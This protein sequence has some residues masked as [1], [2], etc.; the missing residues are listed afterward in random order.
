[1]AAC[2]AAAAVLTGCGGDSGASAGASSPA[3]APSRVCTADD[4]KT[5]GEFGKAPEITVPDDCTPP[6]KLVIKDLSAGT[7][8]E[9]KPGQQVTMNYTLVTW[10]DKKQLDSS[11]GKEP[12]SLSL[13]AGEVIKGW[14]EGLTG[15]KQGGRRLLI[16][17]PDLGY[18]KGGNGIAPNETLVFV[19]DAVAVPA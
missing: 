1:M 2:V 14:D 7:G 18:G 12:F 9:A 3:A 19:V 6:K 4:L 11:F 10:S 5:T 16:I 13:G 8:A 15:I 17:P